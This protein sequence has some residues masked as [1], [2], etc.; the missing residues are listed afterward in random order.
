MCAL[1]LRRFLVACYC[2]TLRLPT[3][4]FSIPVPHGDL[5]VILSG[6]FSYRAWGSSAKYEFAIQWSYGHLETA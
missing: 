5:H 4:V 3:I 6:P 1:L 2:V